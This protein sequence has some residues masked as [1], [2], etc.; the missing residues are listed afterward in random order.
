MSLGTGGDNER[1]NK[2]KMIAMM[3]LAGDAF[4]E[5]GIFAEIA[6]YGGSS[7][8]M[9]DSAFS[10]NRATEDIDYVPLM[11]RPTDLSVIQSVLDE[12]T[13]T[14][15]YSESVF[16]DDVKHMISDNPHHVFFGEYPE[17]KGNFRVFQASPD[18]ILAMKAMSMRSGFISKDPLDLVYLTQELNIDS[19]ESIKSIIH[20][21]FPDYD[22]PTE[23]EFI[24]SDLLNYKNSLGDKEMDQQEVLFI[25][26]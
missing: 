1:F 14:L 13:N 12:V 9:H 25:A 4:Y 7:I 11:T 22:M 2:E 17:G 19:L 21:Y 23:H 3:K 15:G 16:R 20:D 8:M 26:R 6:V 24:I 10:I 18:Y 5:K